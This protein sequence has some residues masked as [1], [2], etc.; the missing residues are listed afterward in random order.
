MIPKFD[1]AI[2]MK[3]FRPISMVGCVYKVI[4]KI[5]ARRIRGVMNNLVGE[6]QTAFLQDRKIYDGALIA[7]ESVHWLKKEK[8]KGLLVKLDFRKAYDS[9]RWSFVDYVMEKMGFRYTWRKWVMN[10][11]SSTSMSIPINGSPTELFNMEKGLR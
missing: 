8:K 9:I 10:C 11:I 5:L 7:C 1:G 2:E 3:D 6:A 4:A